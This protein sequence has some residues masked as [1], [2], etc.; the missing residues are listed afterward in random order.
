M[1]FLGDLRHAFRALVRMP[2]VSAVV[3]LSLAVGIGVNTAVFSWVQAVVLRPIP[4][5]ID[6]GGIQLVEP[7][8]DTGSY[9]GA[10]WREYQDLR[11]RLR[12]IPDLIAFR[13]APFSVGDPGRVER[14]YG[15]L[16]SGNYFAA[17]GLRPALG[18]L[19]RTDEAAQPGG[20]PVVVVSHDYWR[21]HL[22]ADA[23]A[24]G[25]SIRVNDRL[26]T[27]IGVAP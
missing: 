8:A 15:L 27:V 21:T 16:V 4:G 19:L 3:V 23:A 24:I 7:R 6:A 10:S 5:I 22:G 26:L 2:M 20:E 11:A 17:L 13:M 9:P 1:I 14:A 25:R 12:T 18:R